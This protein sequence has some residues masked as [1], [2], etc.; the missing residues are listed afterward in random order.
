MKA[1]LGPY[2][3]V[4]VSI[5]RMIFFFSINVD[6]LLCPRLKSCT[7]GV[8]ELKTA[9]LASVYAASG[10]LMFPQSSVYL[11]YSLS[12]CVSKL[13]PFFIVPQASLSLLVET[14]SQLFV[15]EA[16]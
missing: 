7:C 8:F 2:K 16:L 12:D 10:S 1:K 3:K 11:P 15:L 14:R 4:N 5:W 6:P 9:A 13:E